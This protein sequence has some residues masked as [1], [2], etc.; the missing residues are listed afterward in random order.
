MI[1][2]LL[3]LI[4]SAIRRTHLQSQSRSP[5][6]WQSEFLFIPEKSKP[7]FASIRTLAPTRSIY[8][9]DSRPKGN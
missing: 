9:A 1:T 2:Q 8:P 5:F 7:T 3:N 6:A 4:D